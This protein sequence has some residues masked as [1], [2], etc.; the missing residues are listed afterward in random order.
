MWTARRLGLLV[1]LA[2]AVGLVVARWESTATW[3]C[4]S[5]VSYDYNWN[6]DFSCRRDIFGFD[7]PPDD[8]RL[9]Q[10]QYEDMLNALEHAD[11]D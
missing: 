6:N 10:D 1:L 5:D 8:N 7:R 2:L 4:Y 3:D 9:S 11:D